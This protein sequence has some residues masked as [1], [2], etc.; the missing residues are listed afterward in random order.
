MTG[1]ENDHSSGWNHL[2]TVTMWKGLSGSRWHLTQHDPDVL[3]RNHFLD[4]QTNTKTL[5]PHIKFN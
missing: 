5:K 4:V 2:S 3:G 1:S